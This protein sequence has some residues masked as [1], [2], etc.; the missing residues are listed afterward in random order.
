MKPDSENQPNLWAQLDKL[1]ATYDLKNWLV[2]IDDLYEDDQISREITKET[3]TLFDLYRMNQKED[4]RRKAFGYALLHCLALLQSRQMA[5]VMACIQDL[6]FIGA[7]RELVQEIENRMAST[8]SQ[9]PDRNLD[10]KEI[11]GELLPPVSDLHLFSGLKPSELK[12]IVRICKSV[13]FEAGQ[14]IFEQ[15]ADPHYFYIITDGS[16]RISN[17]LGLNELLG[18]SEFFGEM[19]LLTSQP[20]QAMAVAED[21]VSCLQFSRQD[22]EQLFE[23]SRSL[24]TRIMECFYLRS[25]LNQVSKSKAFK[26]F[27]YSQ[28]CDFFYCF[29]TL[30]TE[31]QQRIFSES[32]ISDCLYFIISGEVQIQNS[33]SSINK[34]LRSGFFGEMGFISGEKRIANAT[35]K[36]KTHLLQL[37]SY[38]LPE[39]RTR[40]PK[41]FE[42]LQKVAIGRELINKGLV[43]PVQS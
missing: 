24:K 34:D 8:F 22:L 11:T 38:F 13:E 2:Q 25:F 40:Y 33:D 14:T 21:K 3:R 43:Q 28:L 16:V 1:F 23:K 15:A 42:I 37:E 27:S 18:V 39:L 6:Q 20:R 35:T 10:L 32:D 5:P 12:S 9:T 19:A 7:P 26:S 31:A 30:V 17:G 36:T 4:H 29:K 41:I